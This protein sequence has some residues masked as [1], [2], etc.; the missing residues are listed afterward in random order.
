M[1][2]NASKAELAGEFDPKNFVDQVPNKDSLP[3]WKVQLLAKQIAEK[4]MKE[5][6]EQRKVKKILQ[7]E[8]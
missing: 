6:L 5:T 7:R 8:F 1:Q 2:D 4:Y 3:S